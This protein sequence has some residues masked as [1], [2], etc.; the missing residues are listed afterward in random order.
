MN[1]GADDRSKRSYTRRCVF[2]A[3]SA[4][5]ARADITAFL[6]LSPTPNN[7]SVKGFS[8][9][10]GLLIVGFEFEYANLSEDDSSCCR[11]SRP[12][13]ATCSCR[14]RSKCWA[15]SSTGRSAPRAIGRRLA[16]SRKRTSAPTSAAARRSSCSDRSACAGLSDFQAA[17]LADPR[18]LSA[19]LRR[20]EPEVLD[21]YRPPGFLSA[22]A[23]SGNG[24]TDMFANS[25]RLSL[26]GGIA[27]ASWYFD[28]SSGA[29]SL[30]SSSSSSDGR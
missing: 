1:I 5:P 11:D 2:L 20:R 7:H 29:T 30:T 4:S 18:R 28:S 15:R 24:A 26:L 6:G 9:G 10:V 14:R 12:T 25:F 22:G 17:G 19:L 16:L 13:P 3:A 8:V 21:R 23:G 27:N